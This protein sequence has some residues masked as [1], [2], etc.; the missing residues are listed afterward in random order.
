MDAGLVPAGS[1]A[2]APLPP[3]FAAVLMKL[4]SRIVPRAG[5]AASGNHLHE[6]F[7]IERISQKTRA[8]DAARAQRAE[9]LFSR[10]R[11]DEIG[12]HHRLARA[13]LVRSTQKNSRREDDQ[14][15]DAGVALPCPAVS[16]R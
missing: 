10:M 13:Y 4:E 14:H 6:R 2:M 7:E 15:L 1:V 5:D 11:R 8:L 16:Y 9:E 3:L 12:L